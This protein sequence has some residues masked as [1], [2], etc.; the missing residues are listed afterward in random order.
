MYYLDHSMTLTVDCNTKREQPVQIYCCY[1]PIAI[2]LPLHHVVNR[3]RTL[4]SLLPPAY[5]G[6]REGTVFT[7][8][9]LS[10]GGVRSSR[11]GGQVQPG[12]V[13]SSCRGGQVQP[14]R[15]SGPARGGQVQLLGGVRSSRVGGGASCW[16]GQPPG[17]GSAKIGQHREYLLH[18]GQY[19]SCVHAGGLSCSLCFHFQIDGCLKY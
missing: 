7:G 14:G 1:T 18:G 8:V 6:R 17:G 11:G 4:I 13:R 3:Y 15:G 12:G 5:V 10:T 16:G 2:A 9:C 19:A